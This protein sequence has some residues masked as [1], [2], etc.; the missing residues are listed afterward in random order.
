MRQFLQNKRFLQLCFA[1]LIILLCATAE[2]KTAS[3]I[4]EVDIDRIQLVSQQIDLLKSRLTQAENDLKQLQNRQDEEIS[5]HA[6]EKAS[7]NL[8]DKASLDISVAKSNLE[9][10]NIELADSQQTIVLLEKNIQEMEN[11]L[12]VYSMFGV[13]VA[14]NEVA[15]INQ[16]RTDSHYQQTLL[17]SEK[18]RVKSLLRLQAVSNN[19]LSLKKDKYNQVSGILRSRK[20]LN[21]KQQQMKEELAFQREQNQWLQQLNRLN[22]QI[23]K[24]DPSQSKALYTSLERNIFYSNENANFAYS[25]SLVARYTDQIQQMKLAISKNSSISL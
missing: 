3:L 19:A 7:R 6:I 8:L 2:A 25:Q 13:K 9:G 14:R 18:I 20:I 24:V 21:L 1:W 12:N 5:P 23:A 16:L 10:I 22:S 15:S 11:Q 17:Q 4:D